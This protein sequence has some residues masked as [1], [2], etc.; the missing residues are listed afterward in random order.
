MRPGTTTFPATDMTD[1][2]CVVGKD[3]KQEPDAPAKAPKL[4]ILIDTAKPVVRLSAGRQGD[5]IVAAW[6]IQEDIPKL[7]TIKLEYRTAE[8]PPEQWLTVK[9]DP[10]QLTG[11]VG[12]PLRS[13]APALVR[14]EIVDA[15][16]NRGSSQ[17]E[18]AAAAAPPGAP[19]PT[20]QVVSAPIPQHG[21]SDSS[22]YS[23]TRAQPTGLTR[24][25]SLQDFPDSANPGSGSNNPSALNPPPGNGIV[26]ATGAAGSSPAAP[27]SAAPSGL[28]PPRGPLPRLE[29]VNTNRL[30]LEYEVDKYGASGVGGVELYV[31][32]DDGA[33]WQ[34]LKEETLN[35]PAPATA[36][37]VS[38]PMP[39]S[40]TA[41]L[42]GE[43]RYGFYLVVR[44]GV[45]L[46]K[47]PPR[48]GET[49]Q[50]RVEVDTTQPVGRLFGL[51]PAPGHRDALIIR[52]EARDANLTETPITLEWAE[53]KNG[54]W[55]VIGG[56][57]LPNTGQYTWKIPANVP[58]RVYM[59]MTIRDLAGNAGV[60]ESAEPVTID[61][62]EPEVKGLR[63]SG[64]GLR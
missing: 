31:T 26:A 47:Q 4:K 22:D 2:A 11:R 34:R 20:A 50:M 48:N 29:Y 45:G 13:S 16:D 37:G 23:P 21:Q 15:A 35:L 44:S 17:V 5:A 62:N 10:P 38:A 30:T 6:D 12:I 42:P 55:E 27:S 57:P 1:A 28:P 51:Q 46:G 64:S 58:P 19:F 63:L 25:H 32:R 60:A 59:R 61:L 33:T 43:G 18:V 54:R 24:T 3:G 49:P 7:D 56:G 8:M 53:H 9:L 52:W 40:I 14:M 36:G 39:R 41:D